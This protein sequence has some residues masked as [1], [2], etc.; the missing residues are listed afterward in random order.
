MMQNPTILKFIQEQSVKKRHINF[1]KTDY[2]DNFD[3][4]DQIYIKL[5]S[6]NGGQIK[7]KGA[8]PNDYG[9]FGAPDANQLG[10]SLD[11]KKDAISPEDIVEEL[12]NW[13]QENIRVISDYRYLFEKGVNFVKANRTD[14][15]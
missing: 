6:C 2:K 5:I 9:G 7:I 14:R 10:H 15:L 13:Y 3:E 11:K 1:A 12:D 4:N 8:F